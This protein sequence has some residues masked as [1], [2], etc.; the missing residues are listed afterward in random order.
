MPFRLGH[1]NLKKAEKLRILVARI[2]RRFLRKFA[3]KLAPERLQVK[4]GLLS[5]RASVD[6]LEDLLAC[7]SLQRPM[8]I[9]EIGTRWGDSLRFIALKFRVK[10]YTAIDPFLSYEEYA[11]DDFDQILQERSGDDIFE[12]TNTLGR[13]LLGKRFTLLRAMSSAAANQIPDGDI[14]FAFVDGNHTYAFV[15]EDLEKFWPKIAPG[16]FLCGHDYFMRSTEHGG[17][18]S[19]AMVFEAVS[20]FVARENVEVDLYGEHRGFPMC[21]AIKKPEHSVARTAT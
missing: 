16:G 8:R 10:S 3:R 9:I 7:L 5:L 12:S 21:F 17:G 18:Y 20:E 19:E 14:D 11:G 4:W 13:A 6:P 2:I 15:K 1:Y